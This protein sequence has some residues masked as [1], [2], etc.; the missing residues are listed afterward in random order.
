MLCKTQG[1]K[2]RN[3]ENVWNLEA[4]CLSVVVD[5]LRLNR[6]PGLTPTEPQTRTPQ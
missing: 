3:K 5:H 4:G 6:R 1:E 2:Q